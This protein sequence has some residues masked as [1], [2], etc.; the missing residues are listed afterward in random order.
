MSEKKAPCLLL[1][2]ELQ[3]QI[4]SYLPFLDQIH[5]MSIAPIWYA[6]LQQESFK[7]IRYYNHIY[8][9]IHRLTFEEDLEIDL[10]VVGGHIGTAS[11]WKRPAPYK[12]KP[13]YLLANIDLKSEQPSVLSERIFRDDFSGFSKDKIGQIHVSLIEVI[14]VAF[15]SNDPNA[16]FSGP[17]KRR[18]LLSEQIN[19]RFEGMTILDLLQF[20]MDVV[21]ASHNL[22]MENLVTVKF[23]LSGWKR[24]RL[25]VVISI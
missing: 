6:I 20:T 24:R 1:P 23:V 5:C 7:D 8:P 3:T 17:W 12:N 2:V 11:I 16:R 9:T 25:D 15:T 18:W 13:Q 22:A 10:H 14:L 4:F 19:P 21:A